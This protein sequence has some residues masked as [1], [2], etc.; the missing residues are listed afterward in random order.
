MHADIFCCD[1]L[2]P[3]GKQFNFLVMEKSLLKKSGHPVE[4]DGTRQR[5]SLKN[6]WWHGVE[7]DVNIF[8]RLRRCTRSE[9]LEKINR[10]A[11]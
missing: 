10:A 6:T 5:E 7:E 4:V 11:G 8:Y 9:Q 1:T 2:Y 3:Y